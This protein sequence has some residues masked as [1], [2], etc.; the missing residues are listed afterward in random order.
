MSC[1]SNSWPGESAGGKK[2]EQL[3]HPWPWCRLGDEHFAISEK[4]LDEARVTVS[5]WTAVN[6][7]AADSMIETA[8]SDGEDGDGHQ[9]MKIFGLLTQ[10]IHGAGR[11]T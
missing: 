4:C 5:S 1:Q 9:V 2:A 8:D 10:M 6:E 11:F 3:G 7:A